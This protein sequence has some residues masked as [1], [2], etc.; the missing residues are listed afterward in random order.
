MGSGT[1]A[2]A[3]NKLGRS[4]IGYEINPDFVPMIRE[5]LS[6][7]DN[8]ELE[9]LQGSIWEPKDQIDYI[10][11][12]KNIDPVEFQKEDDEE[13]FKVSGVEEDLSM[14]LGDSVKL[15]FLGINIID[16]KGARKYLKKYVI[17]KKVQLKENNGERAYFYLT[18]RIFVN[19]ELVKG[20]WARVD[21]SIDHPSKAIL[22]KVERMKARGKKIIDARVMM[23]V[24]EM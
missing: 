1:T 18:N 3:S 10:P 16:I 15:G 5:K 9:V 21:R 22:I 7:L 24:P 13:V 12:I 2:L 23:K 4:C 19:K 17:G 6:C 11:I 14:D 8:S 20:G